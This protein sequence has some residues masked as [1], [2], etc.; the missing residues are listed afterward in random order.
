MEDAGHELLKARAAHQ[1]K[2]TEA[3]HTDASAQ[4]H[5]ERAP[6]ENQWRAK[7]VVKPPRVAVADVSASV[8]PA[9]FKTALFLAIGGAVPAA[10]WRCHGATVAVARSELGS[11]A[12]C[13]MRPREETWPGKGE[14]AHAVRERKI[15]VDGRKKNGPKSRAGA[16]R[17]GDH[18]LDTFLILFPSS[19]LLPCHI[20]HK[21]TRHQSSSAWLSAFGPLRHA[22]L[23]FFFLRHRQQRRNP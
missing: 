17:E 2:R 11:Q 18:S 8:Q 6:Q 15:R 14:G 16:A 21:H 3:P 23:L 4:V 5:T 10:P 19:S 12:V 22:A 7:A 9:F 1:A 20:S 13:K